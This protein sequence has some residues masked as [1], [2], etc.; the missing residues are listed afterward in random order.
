MSDTDLLEQLDKAQALA[1]EWKELYEHE[2]IARQVLETE[3]AR[4]KQAAPSGVSAVVGGEP[5]AS[6]HGWTWA[7]GTETED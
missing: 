4:L 7:R 6:S 5:V 2:R 3:V 1:F